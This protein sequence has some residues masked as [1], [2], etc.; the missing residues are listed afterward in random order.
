M[1]QHN[2]IS[3]FVWQRYKR[4]YKRVL[5]YIKRRTELFI[6]LKLLDQQ[7]VLRLNLAKQCINNLFIISTVYVCAFPINFF[8]GS[9]KI[10]ASYLSEAYFFDSI[11]DIFL[12]S[13]S[14]YFVSL[15]PTSYPTSFLLSLYTAVHSQMLF[16]TYTHLI[17]L[18]YFYFFLNL[19]FFFYSSQL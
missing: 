6:I 3:L 7:Y 13:L 8:L 12:Y 17:Q 5:R 4:I 16:L 9:I 19:F 11:C 14:K 15:I 1:F 10:Y 2:S 18:Y